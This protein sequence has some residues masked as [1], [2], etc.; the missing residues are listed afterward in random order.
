MVTV[1]GTANLEGIISRGQQSLLYNSDINVNGEFNKPERYEIDNK[2]L[3]SKKYHTRHTLD[4]TNK[5]K[6]A[7]RGW[8]IAF[9]FTFIG[10]IV[11]IVYYKRC[12]LKWQLQMLQCN[13]E[14]EQSLNDATDCNTPLLDDT[15]PILISNG[16]ND[17]AVL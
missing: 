13:D 3:Q 8:M 7:A 1:F 14:C 12:K 11:F 4:A 2:M 10:L 5:D 15:L 9:I 16:Y 17:K 6:A